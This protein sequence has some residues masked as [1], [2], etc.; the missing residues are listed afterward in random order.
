MSAPPM[1]MPAPASAARAEPGH[2]LPP[3]E[4][5]G[6]YAVWLAGRGR[7]NR[8]FATAAAA[9][10]RRWPDVQSFAVEPLGAML[11]ADQHTRPFITFL[12]LHDLLRPGF[13]YLAERKFAALVDLAGRT[14]LNDDLQGFIQ[15][16]A[17]LG[18][19]AHVRSRAAERVMARLLIQTG[20]RL[21]EVTVSDLQELEAAFRAR[22]ER[23]G[24]DW[25]N[26]RGFLHAAWTVL[27][28]LG[29]VSLTPPNRRR[30]DHTDHAHHLGGVPAWLARR[31]QDY[32]TALTGT[33]APSTRDGIAIRLAHFGRHLAA[34]D[35]GLSS[36][37]DLDRQRHI[38]T[39]LAAVATARAMRGGQLI[40]AGEQRN[41]IIT[42]GR[43]LTDITEWG[44][45]D[46]PPRRL[47]FSRDIPKLP[48]ALPR[49]L[50]VDADRRIAQALHQ[51]PNR[52]FADALLLARATGL[53]VGELC[54]LEL[55]CI[56]EIPSTGA[57]LKVPLGKLATERM[58]PLDDDTVALIDRIAQTRSPGHPLPHPKTRQPTEFLL[59]HLG[60]RISTAALRE[61][62][63]RAAETAGLPKATPH[64]L[65]HTWATALINSG[66]SL[67]A[68]MV[69][70]GHTSAAMSLRY[71]RL[72]DHTVRADYERAL[73]Q[74]KTQPGTSPDADGPTMLP[75]TDV[76]SSADGWKDTPLIKSRLAGGYCL[77][78]AAQ[79][80][81]TYANICEHCPNFR[82]DAAFLP[83]LAAQ[84]TDTAALLADA[85]ARGWGEE[86]ARH[87]RLLE[88]LDQRM[89]QTEAS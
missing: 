81:C 10:L 26:D 28:H 74:A 65:R 34:I 19:S 50:P 63:A 54:A 79:G 49:Y 38:E 56:H 71:A 68:L 30:H 14:R 24:S 85:E 80:S 84:R 62:L 86:A 2:R 89:A 55:D 75:I 4:L 87:R 17:E 7:G 31:L 23:R 45:P 76:T 47:I 40:S 72:F 41:R 3:A 51:S 61:E 46:A 27:F 20:R 6:E 35:S 37:A 48:R 43:F 82:T 21:H 39:Y 73:A 83:V 60:K 5:L 22:A 78:T 1:T 52:M 58:V 66:C 88:R 16:A 42:L 69:M 57:W 77:R 25:G 11:A 12:L 29:V 36:L 53:R 70:L 8:C 64:Q 44:W 9:F 59:T 18:F 32:L 15:A 33:H 67:Q 13:D